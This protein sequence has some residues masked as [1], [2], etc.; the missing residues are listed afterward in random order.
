MVIMNCLLDILVQLILK[1]PIRIV[2]TNLQ[3]TIIDNF[4]D[5]N[6]LKNNYYALNKA[7]V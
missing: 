2:I 6:T 5:V 1:F 4:S 7:W 3:T